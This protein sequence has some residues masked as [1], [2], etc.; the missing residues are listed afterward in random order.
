MHHSLSAGFDFAPPVSPPSPHPG[1]LTLAFGFVFGATALFAQTANIG[2]PA[3]LTNYEDPGQYNFVA[4]MSSANAYIVGF[5]FDSLGDYRIDSLTLLL[6]GDADLSDFSLSV[7]STLPTDLT[8]PT[9]I[10]T[11]SGSGTL[12]GTA[13]PTTFTVNLSETLTADTAYYLRIAYM[14]SDTANWVKVAGNNPTTSSPPPLTILDEGDI[15]AVFAGDPYF[16]WADNSITYRQATGTGFS[17][18]NSTVGGFSLAAS[19]FSAV[20]EPASVAGLAGAATLLSAFLV[21]RRRQRD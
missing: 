14:G 3:P 16:S 6:A 1:L 9:A 20:P 5:K 11:F 8:L 10:T 2:H 19:A 18:I 13:T 7:S 21:R 4:G 12:T 15:L 17:D